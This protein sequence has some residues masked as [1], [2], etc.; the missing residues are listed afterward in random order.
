MLKISYI[1][2]KNPITLKVSMLHKGF[3][4]HKYRN[5]LK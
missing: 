5:V 3:T 1:K 2:E 4:I